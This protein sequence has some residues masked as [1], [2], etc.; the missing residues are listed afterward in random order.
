MKK[1]SIV[2]F[3]YLLPNLLC[4][5]SQE[6]IEQASKTADKII[7]EQQEKLIQENREEQLKRSKTTLDYEQPAVTKK[8]DKGSCRIIHN[9]I[10]DTELEWDIFNKYKFKIF[11]VLGNNGMKEKMILLF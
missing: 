11:T 3:F 5:A 2:L 10:I 4:A 6:D 8:V 9:I 1:L 7:R